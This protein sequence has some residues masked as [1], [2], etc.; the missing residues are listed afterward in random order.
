M[1]DIKMKRVLVINGSNNEIMLIQAAKRLGYYVITTGNNPTLIGHKYA[2]EYHS[3]DYSDY[4]AMLALAKSLRIDAVISNCNDL[5]MMTA[6]YINHELGLPGVYDDLE[7]ARVF[8]EKDAFKAFATEHGFSTPAGKVFDDFEAAGEFLRHIEFPVMIKPIDACGGRGISRAESIDEGVIALKKAFKQSIAKRIV[9][10]E[11][12]QGKQYDLHAIVENQKIVLFYASNEYTYKNPYRVSALTMPADHSPE[13]TR[14]I[15]NDIERMAEILKIK[16]G[17]LWLQY[18]VK[19]GKAFIV[20]SSRRCGGNNMIDLVSNGY[21]KDI[22]EYMVRL[23]TGMEYKGFFDGV[24]LRKPQGY[25]SF[26]APYNGVVDHIEISDEL[27]KHIYKEWYWC[28]DAQVIEDY[29]HDELGVVLFEYDSIEEMSKA[30]D[31]IN[32]DAK[33]VMQ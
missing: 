27:R 5:G 21:G 9:I 26:M 2:D 22:G 17:L 32:R 23:E 10:E 15:I 19:N 11:Y 24:T 3:A 1:G 16:D 25:Q 8:H 14:Q 13:I 33:V 30:L 31:T 6:T 29:L 7:T 28:K 18:R 20:E 12:I 4:D